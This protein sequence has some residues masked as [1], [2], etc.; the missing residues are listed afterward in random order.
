MK[1]NI[2]LTILLLCFSIN[3]YCDADSINMAGV[4]L[5]I[6]MT[7]EALEKK[8]SGK[9]RLVIMP[10]DKNEDFILI[11]DND[12]RIGN[13]TVLNN[14][15]VSIEKE[16]NDFQDSKTLDMADSIAEIMIWLLGN[17]KSGVAN[18][19]LSTIKTDQSSS[20]YFT[21][22]K[23]NKYFQMSITR[24]SLKSKSLSYGVSINKGLLDD[25]I[26]IK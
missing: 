16:V 24:V 12:M 20:D 23:G 8:L 17:E 18:I 21:I 25:K 1:K 3:S 19:S 10:R 13:L 14:R 11:M 2:L 9:Y 22:K 7:R 5:K 6:G 26:Q 4:D 15:I